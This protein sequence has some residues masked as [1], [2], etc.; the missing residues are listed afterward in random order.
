MKPV[1]FWIKYYPFICLQ[2]NVQI[3]FVV[4]NC[5]VVFVKYCVYG[6]NCVLLHNVGALE[7]ALISVIMVIWRNEFFCYYIDIRH[8][9]SSNCKS[10]SCY[11]MFK[12]IWKTWSESHQQIKCQVH[13]ASV[14]SNVKFN[15]KISVKYSAANGF[16]STAVDLLARDSAIQ[17]YEL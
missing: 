5:F 2:L 14:K 10:N 7:T 16:K 15:V 12:I 8:Q 6:R 4:W 17:D 13:H 11:V 1:I 9:L 3:Y